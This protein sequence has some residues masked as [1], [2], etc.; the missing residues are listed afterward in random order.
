MAIRKHILGRGTKRAGTIGPQI[1]TTFTGHR[2]LQLSAAKRTNIRQKWTVNRCSIL[3]LFIGYFNKLNSLDL[4]S[5]ILWS[6]IQVLLTSTQPTQVCQVPHLFSTMESCNK[7]LEMSADLQEKDSDIPWQSIAESILDGVGSHVGK[8]LLIT[9]SGVFPKG[10][11]TSRYDESAI[12]GLFF[13]AF[14][15]PFL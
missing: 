5:E 13:Q 9:W 11:F 3:K 12:S 15:S 4:S 7:I 6:E 14:S 2:Y 10:A 8:D 1:L